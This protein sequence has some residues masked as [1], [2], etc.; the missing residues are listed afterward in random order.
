MQTKWPGVTVAIGYGFVLKKFHQSIIR[1]DCNG[2]LLHFDL[3]SYARVS[4]SSLAAVRKVLLIIVGNML[5]D[6]AWTL[7]RERKMRSLC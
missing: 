5:V 3:K 1:G 6:F 4:M 7:I 2:L